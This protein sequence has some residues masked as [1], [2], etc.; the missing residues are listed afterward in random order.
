MHEE[1]VKM[2]Y[3]SIPNGRYEISEIV[4]NIKGVLIDLD[5]EINRVSIFFENTVLALRVCDEGDRLRTIQGVLANKGDS[6]FV[7]WP[8]YI[9]K[10]SEFSKWFENETFE[11][12]KQESFKHFAIVTPN[13]VVDILSNHEPK[14]Q[15]SKLLVD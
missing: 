9:V 10:N 5:D 11:I 7:G 14:I 13:D 12:R 2:E 8:I 3:A 1:F 15:V 6:F 4:Q